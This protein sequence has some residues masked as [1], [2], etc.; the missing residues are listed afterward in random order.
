MFVA[1]IVVVAVLFALYMSVGNLRLF[2]RGIKIIYVLLRKRQDSPLFSLSVPGQDPALWDSQVRVL[3][4]VPV[5]HF[6]SHRLHS[7]HSRTLK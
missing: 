2:L 7:I 4:I 3:I 6:S 1:D 5:P